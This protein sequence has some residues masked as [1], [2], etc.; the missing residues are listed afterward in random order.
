MSPEESIHSALILHVDLEIAVKLMQEHAT[1]IGPVHA[2]WN[3]IKVFEQH[4]S[5]Y[6]RS[7]Y[8]ADP[9]DITESGL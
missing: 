7:N 1:K 2:W 6:R 8:L 9:K 5:E 4:L 3:Y